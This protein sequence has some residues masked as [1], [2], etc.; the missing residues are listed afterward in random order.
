MKPAAAVLLLARNTP[1][2]MQT[3][4]SGARVA[5][6]PRATASRRCVPL[7]FFRHVAGAGTR[8]PTRGGGA[9]RAPCNRLTHRRSARALSACST[10]AAA[11]PL[12]GPM[13][14]RCVPPPA[15]RCV[16]RRRAHGRMLPRRAGARVAAAR[17]PRCRKGLRAISW[18]RQ[19]SLRHCALAAASLRRAAPSSARH[20]PCRCVR[21]AVCTQGVLTCPAQA[22]AVRVRAA[23][24]PGVVT[25]TA[26]S[27]SLGGRKLRV[28]VRRQRSR[29]RLR[30][31]RPA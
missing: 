26:S 25:V 13:A 4:Q 11:V 20:R 27:K 21:S 5:V 14:S 10:A 12:A 3:L 8:A 22:A 23:S 16:L 6:A 1:A 31:R 17:R 29:L 28:A 24:A 2:A 7:L 18:L 30:A 19:L 9:R 15:R